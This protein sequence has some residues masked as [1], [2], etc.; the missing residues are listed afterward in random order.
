MGDSDIK[1][2]DG[3]AL[4]YPIIGGLI[5]IKSFWRCDNMRWC[6]I[7]LPGCGCESCQYRYLTEERGLSPEE[8]NSLIMGDG[9]PFD[10]D[11]SIIADNPESV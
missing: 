11:E 6:E 1:S 5:P 2:L 3:M 9:V 7:E 8:A 4:K 10:S